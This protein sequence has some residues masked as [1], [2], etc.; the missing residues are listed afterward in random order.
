MIDISSVNGGD[1]LVLDTQVPKAANLLQVQIGYLEYA[2]D[3][4]IDLEF[5][6]D[7]QFQFQNESFK[8]YL[9]Q[10]L[11]ENH[12]NVNQVF[13]SIDTFFEKYTFTVGDP[14]VSSGGFIK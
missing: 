7:P 14:E 3:F 8:A 4:G 12:V 6:L 1:L 11:S 13:D 2:Q 10:R 9:I 5:F